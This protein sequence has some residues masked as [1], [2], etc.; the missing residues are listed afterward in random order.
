MHCTSNI[1]FSP[2]IHSCCG[3]WNKI[4][5]VFLAHSQLCVSKFKSCTSEIHERHLHRATGDKSL[6]H[7]RFNLDQTNGVDWN[8]W[9]SLPSAVHVREIPRR[10]ATLISWN[11][12]YQLTLYNKWIH[13]SYLYKQSRELNCRSLKHDHIS[14]SRM[15]TPDSRDKSDEE[16][17]VKHVETWN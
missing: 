5:V 15:C 11:T 8:E 1:F 7:V 2:H 10:N 9:S 13:P 17:T 16:I 6:I 12:I 14:Y 3:H 4:L